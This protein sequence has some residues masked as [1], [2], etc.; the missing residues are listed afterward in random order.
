MTRRER[1]Q[2][3]ADRLREWADKREARGDAGWDRAQETADRIPFGQ[4]ILAGHHSEGRDRRYRQRI[5]DTFDKAAADLAKAR[6]MRSRATHIDDE[7]ASSIYDDDP[8]AIPALKARI[9]SLE[10]E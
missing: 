7:L 5:S 4:P 10:A 3:R 6:D 1:R 2:A 9:A 8:D